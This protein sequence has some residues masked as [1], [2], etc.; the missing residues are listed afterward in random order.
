MA[1]EEPTETLAVE[2]IDYVL[3]FKEVKIFGNEAIEWG[4]TSVTL[5]PR[6]ASVLRASGEPGTGRFRRNSEP[7]DLR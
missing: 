6:G 1:G 5:R 7:E 4:R 3:D 2:I